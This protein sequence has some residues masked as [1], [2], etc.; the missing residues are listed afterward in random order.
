MGPDDG[1]RRDYSVYPSTLARRLRVSE[2]DR[3]QT[4][5]CPAQRLGIGKASHV[6]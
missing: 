6:A 5:A 4:L 3:K 2:M 1:G